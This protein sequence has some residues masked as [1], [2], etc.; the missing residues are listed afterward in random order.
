MD[1]V[2]TDVRICHH[3]TGGMARWEPGARE[4]MQFAALDLFVELGF[5][6]TTVAAI[7]AR[8]AVTER[9]FYRHF[10]DKREVLFRGEALAD[11][12]RDGISGA[13]A[14]CGTL[15]VIG[16]AL[17]S[18]GTFFSG[19][20]REWSRR[21]QTAIDADDALREREQLKLAALADSAAKAFRVRGLDTGAARLAAETTIALFKVAFAAW[22]E[23][24]E[25]CDFTRLAEAAV[26]DLR[27]LSGSNS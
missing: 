24:G 18:L 7:A 13:A 4:R 1:D 16:K 3:Y 26:R 17:D 23:P 9:T 27:T 14:T 20:R 5:E 22:I 25:E 21:R 2:S 12:L 8:A 15:E 6:R 10:A 19:E 11:H